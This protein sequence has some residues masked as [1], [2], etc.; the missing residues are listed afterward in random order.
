MPWRLW[1]FFL[2]RYRI[3]QI[4]KRCFQRAVVNL[5]LVC[6]KPK[7]AMIQFARRFSTVTSPKKPHPIMRNLPLVSLMV[8]VSALSFQVGVL[9]PWHAEL[10]TQFTTLEVQCKY[11]I[12]KFF[13]WYWYL[14]S[15][16]L[17]I[18]KEI[19]ELHAKVTDLKVLVEKVRVKEKLVLD[20][21]DE[22][23]QKLNEFMSSE[24]KSDD[25]WKISN[26]CNNFWDFLNFRMF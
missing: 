11:L 8:G 4:A 18:G 23:L 12:L 10:T 13:N 2:A 21:E 3:L 1:Y 26:F 16:T 15:V 19:E 25:G 9:F 6:L 22:V 7:F 14:Q 20:K 24:E 17:K 5:I